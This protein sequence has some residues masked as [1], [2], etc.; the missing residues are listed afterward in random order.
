MTVAQ[1]AVKKLLLEFR[2]TCFNKRQIKFGRD[3]REL[4]SWVVHQMIVIDERARGGTSLLK[5]RYC[6]G[7]PQE[8]GF[9][10]R[11]L[12]AMGERFGNA[13]R[14]SEGNHVF[15]A[16]FEAREYGLPERE[17]AGNPWILERKDFAFA[18]LAECCDGIGLKAVQTLRFYRVDVDGRHGVPIRACSMHHGNVDRIDI[19]IFEE[20]LIVYAFRRR[21]QIVAKI[22]TQ[23][24]HRACQCAG[25][26]SMHAKNDDQAGVAIRGRKRLCLC[27][28]RHCL[29]GLLES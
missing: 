25:A 14:I 2:K 8:I 4:A 11:K 9:F 12:I 24:T 16:G 1:V 3:S 19:E 18:F 10:F 22:G 28:I 29:D 5:C 17:K 13:Y 21:H 20:A 27:V 15:H 23:D 26:T 6:M 7:K